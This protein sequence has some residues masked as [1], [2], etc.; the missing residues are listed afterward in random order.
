MTSEKA[1]RKAYRI[2][3]NVTPLKTDCG[4]LCNGECCKGDENTGML[5]FPGEEEFYKNSDDFIVKNDESNRKILICSGKCDRNNRPLSCRI[6]PLFPLV[7]DEKI[8][9]ID[10]P[11][12][13]GICPLIYDQ[14]KLNK[15]FERKVGKAAR[16][17]SKNDKTFEFLESV[18][19]EISEILSMTYDLLG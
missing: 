18:S 19:D 5:L 9:V 13:S 17:L 14:I 6:F 4:K 16:I 8:Y 11:R 1:I 2:L 10:D 15:T 3:R 12:A 7:C